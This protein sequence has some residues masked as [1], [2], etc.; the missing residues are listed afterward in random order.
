MDYSRA[1]DILPNQRAVT[2]KPRNPTA[3]NITIRAV[4]RPWS[5]QEVVSLGPAMVDGQPEKCVFLLPARDTSGAAVVP[6]NTWKITDGDSNTWTILSAT[7]EM[8]GYLFRCAVS[9]DAA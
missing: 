6:R 3:S 4:R 7:R 8:E 5:Q 1:F 2:L 9:L